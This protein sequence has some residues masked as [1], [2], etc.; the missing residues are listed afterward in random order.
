MF[1]ANSIK[2][3]FR[4]SS[5]KKLRGIIK[6]VRTDLSKDV[7]ENDLGNSI[8]FKR[9]QCSSHPLPVSKLFFKSEA[10]MDSAIKNGIYT[11][12]EHFGKEVKIDIIKFLH[13]FNC[14]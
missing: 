3:D 4:E 10:E 5:N 2:A 14:Q 6:D 7:I 12:N 1:L 11:A 8:D 13:C 9:Y